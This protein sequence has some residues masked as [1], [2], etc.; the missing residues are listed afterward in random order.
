MMKIGVVGG[1]AVGLLIAGYLSLR[2]P[3][4]LYVRRN[5]QKRLLADEGLTVENG[6]GR[7]RGFRVALSDEPWEDDVILL[8][9]KQHQ[10]PAL[11]EKRERPVRPGQALMFLQ[12]GAGHLRLF[13]RLDYE[14]L[15]VGIVEHGA[16]KRSDTTVV[17]RGS[18]RILVAAVRGRLSLLDPLFHDASFPFVP[19][20]D[21]REIVNQKWLANTV[22]NPL[23]ALYRVPNGAL[24]D[25]EPLRRAM[26]NV[27]D[28]AVRVID[29]GDREAAWRRLTA[30]CRQT[31]DNRSSMLQDIEAGRKTEIDAI[32][33]EAL[34]VAEA[35]GEKL[36]L[37]D[38]LYHSILGLERGRR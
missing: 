9:V 20:D 35:R 34:A 24:L 36:A 18:G 21:W 10:L 1:G 7:I 22:I 17:H 3:V 29:V 32:L 33:G 37:I 4:T 19:A 28:E 16:W 25:N 2:F 38:F 14:N 23:T 15:Y 6:P 12:N 5:A 11:L 26:R 30:I 13:D 27:F 31:R 8:A